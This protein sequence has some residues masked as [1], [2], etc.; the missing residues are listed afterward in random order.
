M[1]RLRFEGLQVWR[2]LRGGVSSTIAIVSTLMIG[3]GLTNAIF[4]M[5]DPFLLAPLPYFQP[6][7]LVIIQTELLRGQDGNGSAR[8]IP[9]V[10]DWRARSEFFD[11]LAAYGPQEQV[12]IQS[13]TGG[14]SILKMVPVSS[15]FFQVLHGVSSLNPLW[16]NQ[17]PSNLVERDIAISRQSLDR[18]PDHPSLLLAAD[19]RRL[20]VAAK[21]PRDFLFP[22]QFAFRRPDAVFLS[23]LGSTIQISPGRQDPIVVVARLRAGVRAEV[24]E[25]ALATES[26]S[27]RISV[28]PISAYLKGRLRPLALGTLA[29]SLLIAFVCIANV[30]NLLLAKM[31]HRSRDLGTRRALGASKTDLFVHLL[32]ELAALSVLGAFAGLL[33]SHCILA[34]LNQIV[35]AEY[36]ALGQP[37]LTMRVGVFAALLG[38]VAFTTF[39]LVGWSSLNAQETHRRSAWR[40][41]NASRTGALRF[42]AVASQ[43]AVAAVLLVGSTLLLRSY[44]NLISQDTGFAHD[45]GM[46]STLYPKDQLPALLRQD[47]EATLRTINLVPGVSKSA[48]IA[49]PMLDDYGV[50]GGTLLRIAGRTLLQSARQ[51]SAGYFDTTGISVKAGRG[52]L[53]EDKGWEAIVVNEALAK[54]LWPQ[55]G[56]GDIVGER[57]VMENAVTGG[58]IIGVVENTHDRSLDVLPTPMIYRPLDEPRANLPIHFVIQVTGDHSPVIGQV[59]RAITQVSRDATVLY[60][61]SISDRMAST[62]GDRSF[63]TLVMSLFSAA[64]VSV[65]AS[66]LFGV[67]TFVVGRRTR[68]IAIRRAVGASARHILFLVTRESGT[69]ACAGVLVGLLF[70]R[71]GTALL[72]NYVYGIDAGDSAVVVV[73]AI[74][75]VGLVVLAAWVPARRALMLPPTEA[76]RVD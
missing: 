35:P 59:R 22:T 36:I 14:A 3:L 30:L 76:L 45:V 27:V 57:F 54:R 46:V 40:R 48:V 9:N 18:L 31:T 58:E 56:L 70:A 32:T 12:R 21:W 73:A 38:S 11:D 66:G 68:E 50:V 51:V 41:L 10:R 39:V 37:A 34:S 25:T 1:D 2:A 4:A 64:A 69:A 74:G 26:Q 5:A 29:A 16:G 47:L 60:A 33:L 28:Q 71:W 52:F 17:G 42:V 72:T 55:Q 53:P 62:V 15:S 61:G 7:R 6:E 19:G 13:A 49:G 24:V 67:V 65:T 75:M 20:R 63:A 8:L 43:S 23:Q 44:V